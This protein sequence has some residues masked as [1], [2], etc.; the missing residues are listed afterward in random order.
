MYEEYENRGFP[1]RNFLLKLILIIIFVFL[2]VWLLP[3]FIA[4]TINKNIKESNVSSSE[5]NALTSQIFSDNLNKM[6]EAAISYYTDERL[7]QEEGEFKKMT[8]SEMIGL[9]IITPLIDK[10]NK[11]VDVEASYVKITKAENEYILKVNIKDSEKEDYILVHLGCYTYCKGNICEKKSENI[12]IKGTTITPDTPV[13]KKYY[14]KIANGKYYGKYGN[15]VNKDAYENECITK[16]EEKHYCAIVNDKYYGKA[17]TVVS[18]ETYENECTS[19][20]EEKHY[21]AIVNDK[22]YGKDGTVVTKETYENECTSKPEEKHYCE[23]VNGKYY[24]KNGNIVD[25]NAYEDSCKT[26]EYLYEY[27]RTTNATFSSWTK[28]ANWTETSCSTKAITCAASDINCLR[29]VKLYNRKEKIGTHEKEYIKERSTQIEASSYSA[30]T[31]TNYTYVIINNVT[32]AVT[33]T[34]TNVTTITSGT[35][36]SVDGWSYNGRGSYANPP[37][38]TENTH[39]EFV[40]ADYSYCSDTCTTLPNYYYDKYTYTG[41]M[42]KV[43]STT[44]AP[45][46]S[47]SSVTATCGGYTTKTVYVYR[48]ITKT[49]IAT[50]T[51]PL[52]GTVCY[53]SDRTRKLTSTGTTEKKWSYYNDTTLLNN[54]W[55]YTGNKKLK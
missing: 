49:E 21:C 46:S 20:P 9:K 11:P 47:S 36:S 42:S 8:L 29:E 18:K 23:I 10:N 12:V 26:K 50:R 22:Y 33:K 19:K 30:K 15:V 4:P 45:T 31:C 48:N 2:L 41:S 6:K 3:K 13:V 39:Y 28:W 27:A 25:K 44:E 32:Y 53:S 35:Q 51:E 40:G 7:P 37:R 17:G 14:C 55:Y 16:P 1:F 34:Y 38:D 5:I 52:Y 54:N 24:D 43:T